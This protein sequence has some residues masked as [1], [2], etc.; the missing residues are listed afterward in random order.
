[1]NGVEKVDKLKK[2]LS[3]W[4]IIIKDNVKEETINMINL[5][6]LKAR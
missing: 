4:L 3:T 2:K 1:M 5:K 6:S